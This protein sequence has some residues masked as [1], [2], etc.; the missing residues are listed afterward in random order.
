MNRFYGLITCAEVSAIRQK[1]RRVQGQHGKTSEGDQRGV[2]GQDAADLGPQ[3]EGGLGKRALSERNC[4]RG[5]EAWVEGGGLHVPG[6][7]Q[8]RAGEACR[9]AVSSA[10][11]HPCLPSRISQGSFTALPAALPENSGW[12]KTWG[13][14]S[15]QIPEA[16]KSFS[17][18]LEPESKRTLPLAQKTLPVPV[19]PCPNPGLG[20]FHI[21]V[22]SK[23]QTA[24]LQGPR[25]GADP[26]ALSSAGQAARLLDEI[27]WGA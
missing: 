26:E 2:L 8:V 20:Q 1:G 9:G 4:V 3:E 14:T 16:N 13:V 18:N 7:R 11:L 10:S 15:V 21:L 24:G 17:Q 25:P 27:T 19:P 22:Q 12:P 6:V 5:S 23:P